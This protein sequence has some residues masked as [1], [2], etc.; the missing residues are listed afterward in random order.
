MSETTINAVE[1]AEK[2]YTLREL[3]ARDIAPMASILSKIGIKDIKECFNG[4]DLKD[5]ASGKADE[6]TIN[7]IGMSIMLDIV[8]IV[9]ENYS[10]CQDN[11]FKFLASLSGMDAKQIESLRNSPRT[12]RQRQFAEFRHDDSQTRHAHRRYRDKQRL[13]RLGTER[14]FDYAHDH[15]R[16]T[17][18]V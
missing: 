18:K 9:L 13:R 6:A 5:L 16:G 15:K 14:L 1:T 7:A 3:E 10:K 2:V 11:V 8:G 4:Q 12:C 17:Q